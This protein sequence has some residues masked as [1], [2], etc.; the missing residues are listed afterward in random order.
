MN[1]NL[2]KNFDLFLQNYQLVRQSF[3]WESS[4][5]IPLSAS[6]YTNKGLNV[7]I[8]EIKKCKKLVK[9]TT[10]FFSN[11]KGIS[12]LLIFTMLSLQ[13]N[14]EKCLKNSIKIYDILKKQFSSSEYLTD[15]SIT[16]SRLEE[17]NYE[18]LA[19]RAKEIYKL[20]KKSHFFLTG[21]DDYVYAILFALKNV[22]IEENNEIIEECYRYLND[23]I[24]KGDGIQN[25]SQVI[26][27]ENG[28]DY[29]KT[30]DKVFEIRKMLKENKLNIGS[31]VEVSILSLLASLQMSNKQIVEEITEVYN[32]LKTQKGFGV[33]YFSKAGRLMYSAMLVYNTYK[34]ENLLEDEKKSKNLHSII[35]SIISEQIPITVSIHSAIV[36]ANAST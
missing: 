36:S 22:S 3:N 23:E 8:D 35:N 11:F 12:S 32:L 16:L 20:M 7:N 26:V 9:E 2:K 30:C 18:D 28:A 27:L 24:S 21:G 19:L 33:F 14:S 15:I 4:D 6:I 31:E 17:L 10:G 13:E 1:D 5:M 29:K 25:L 34:K